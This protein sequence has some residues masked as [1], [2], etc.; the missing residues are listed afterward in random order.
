M[1]IEKKSSG[2]QARYTWLC[3]AAAACWGLVANAAEFLTGVKGMDAVQLYTL[4]RDRRSPQAGEALSVAAAVIGA[5]ILATDGSLGSLVISP[6]S[7][8]SA[9][10]PHLFTRRPGLG[11]EA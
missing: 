8:S 6:F 2:A 3:V 4:V 5:F 10:W 7:C 11:S 1:T 9:P